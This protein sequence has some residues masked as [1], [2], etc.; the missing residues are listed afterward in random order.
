M[1]SNVR[2]VVTQHGISPAMLI[3]NS[4]QPNWETVRI[5]DHMENRS[6]DCI[7]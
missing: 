7:G 3:Q 1:I 4:Y 6:D 5:S 2:P